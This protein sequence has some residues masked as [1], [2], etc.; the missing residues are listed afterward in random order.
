MKQSNID[1]NTYF[2]YDPLFAKMNKIF[3]KSMRIPSHKKVASEN[4]APTADESESN[5]V[6]EDH[7]EG[8]AEEYD[9]GE[10]LKLA[11]LCEK[12]ELI[13]NSKHPRSV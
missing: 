5:D 6:L 8:D 4:S 1:P 10:N 3:S 2:E 13:W 9:R 11:V 7:E 12:N